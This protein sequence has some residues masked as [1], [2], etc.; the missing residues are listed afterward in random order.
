MEGSGVWAM[1]SQGTRN[2]VKQQPRY[3]GTQSPEFLA[4]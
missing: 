4:R 1:R 2:I 3:T